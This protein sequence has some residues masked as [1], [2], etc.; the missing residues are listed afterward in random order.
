[1][2]AIELLILLDFYQ[3]WLIVWVL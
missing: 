1:M 3:M 2:S